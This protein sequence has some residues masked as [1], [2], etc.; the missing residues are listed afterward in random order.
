MSNRR[1]A[2]GDVLHDNDRDGGIF[3]PHH[4]EIESAE[5]VQ[6]YEAVMVTAEDKV[7]TG[8]LA[9]FRF[10]KDNRVLPLG[11]DKANAPDDIAV[12]GRARDDADF[13]GGEERVRYAVDVSG[14]EGPF[15]VQAELWYQP[16]GYRWAQ[17]LEQ[18]QAPEIERFVSYYQTMSA[19]SAVLLARDTKTVP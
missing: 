5:Q 7:T 12:Q 19:D 11:F 18:H 15:T 9:A 16:I 2:S 10:A 8:L 17:N 13:G 4:T 1:E 14:G 6:V 3:E